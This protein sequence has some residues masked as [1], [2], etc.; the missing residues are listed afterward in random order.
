MK[1][2]KMM[3]GLQYSA[4]FLIAVCFLIPVLW[5][6]T[7][8]I[9]PNAGQ[10]I[11]IPKNPTMANFVDVLTNMDNLRGFAN[12]LFLAIFE[13]VIVVAVSILAAYPLSRYH[14]SWKQKFLYIII[15]MTA[16]PVNAV[17]I[18]VYRLFVSWNVNDNL[19]STGLFMAATKLPYGIWMM[20][21]FMDSVP[22]SLEESSWIDGASTFQSMRK[23]IAPLMVPGIFTVFIFVFTGAW[24]TFFLPFILIQSSEKFPAAV[25]IYQF[26]TYNGLV[27]YGKLAAYSLVYTMPS[28]VLYAFAQNFMSKGF[29]MGGADKG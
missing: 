7:A 28:I 12:G 8:S 22:V 23:I 4:L 9:D 5:I 16:L 10:A 13:A 3:T 2:K 24:G 21:N 25:R 1:K 26:F 14:M 29:S 18:P 11:R 19:V 20:K 15:F 27:E 17:T 6:V